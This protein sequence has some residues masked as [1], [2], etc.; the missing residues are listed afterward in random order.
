MK[1][2]RNKYSVLVIIFSIA[3]II[4]GTLYFLHLVGL[5]IVMLFLGLTQVSGGFSQINKVQQI[6]SKEIDKTSRVV[7]CF[8]IVLGIIIIVAVVIKMIVWNVYQI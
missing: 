2:N 1:V 8:S 3:T 5:D 6:D 7:G 4:M